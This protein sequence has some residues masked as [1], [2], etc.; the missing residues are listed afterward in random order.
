MITK[1]IFW[2][3]AI[4]GVVVVLVTVILA[5]SSGSSIRI[6]G[7]HMEGTWVVTLTGSPTRI[8]QTF[9]A[10]GTMV[11]VT[12]NFLQSVA[13]G[14]WVRT[15][16]R[17]FDV[18]YIRHRWDTGGNLLGSLKTR[19]RLTLNETLDEWSGSVKADN[20]DLDGNFVSSLGGVGTLQAKRI[21]I[22]PLE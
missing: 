21:G 11:V 4:A 9:H 20:F 1:R 15:G 5:Q 22:E 6:T 16:D 2:A 7:Q 19:T 17:Q 18:T 3:L 14:E 12:S 8:L 10:D 13:V